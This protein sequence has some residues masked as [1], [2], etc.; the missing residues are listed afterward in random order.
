MQTKGTKQVV[1]SEARTS[2]SRRIG[3][4]LETE[5]GRYGYRRVTALL[6][7]EAW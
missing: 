5:Y 3:I 4:L 6:N 1:L 2:S 7:R